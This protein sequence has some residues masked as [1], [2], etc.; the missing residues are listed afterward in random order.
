MSGMHLVRGMSTTSTKKRKVNRKP[1]WAE[2]QSKHDAWLRKMGVHPE[3]MKGK[4]KDA[5][6]Q[7]PDYGANKP[8]IPT[9]DRICGIASKREMQRYTGTLI[10]GVATMHKSNMVPVTNGKDAKEIARMRRG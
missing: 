3:Q 10:K 9:S 6:L 4:V 8:A 7:I 5:S 2:A 1:G